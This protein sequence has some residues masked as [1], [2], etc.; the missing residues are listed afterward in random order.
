MG[1]GF[2]PGRLA[3]QPDPAAPARA[4]RGRDAPDALTALAQEAG[5]GA[6]D[7]ATGSWLS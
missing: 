4:R 7:P 2:S 3:P 5:G 6:R 1:V